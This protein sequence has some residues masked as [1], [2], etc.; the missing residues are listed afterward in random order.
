[1]KLQISKRP[2]AISALM[3]ALIVGAPLL[4]Q[5][6]SAQ[7]YPGPMT[8]QQREELAT[9]IESYDSHYDAAEK[10]MAI[11]KRGGYDY[12]TNLGA[13]KVHPT[14]VSLSYAIALLDSREPAHEAR[15]F[16]ILRRV[17]ELQ[18][19][20]PDSAGYGVWPKYA[21]EALEAAPYIDRNWADF[22]GKDLLY[23][24]LYHEKR[25]PADLQSALKTGILNAA[26]SIRQ[27]NITLAYTNIAV[28]GTYVTLMA[29]EHYG[30]ADLL[31]YARGRLR[32]LSAFTQEFGLIEYNSPNYNLIALEDSQR[33]LRDVRDP[34]DREL[35]SQIHARV[36]RELATHF[37]APTR[38]WIGPYSRVYNLGYDDAHAAWI[39]AHTGP[40]VDWGLVPLGLEEQ[41]A[42]LLCPPELESY[43]APL[44]QARTQ[45]QTFDS[46]ATPPVIG[47]TFLHPQFALGSINQGEMWNQRR[48]LL[49]YWGAPGSVST[50]ALRFLHDG[51]DFQS[52]NI[53]AQQREGRALVALTAMT[54]GGDK[55]PSL[56]RIK[57]ATVKSKDW[58]VRWEFGGAARDVTIVAPDS[59]A[60]NAR[61][62][63]GGLRF[64][65]AAPVAQWG[66]GKGRWE[67]GHDDQTAWLD[68]VLYDGPEKAWKLDEMQRIAVAMALQIS[69]GQAAPMAP[70]KIRNAD[71]Q[72]TL[73][74]NDLA[75]SVSTRPQTAD[76]LRKRLRL[77]S[78]V[79]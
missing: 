66:P 54:D 64:E 33:L 14:R 40:S 68:I 2:R 29:A 7:Y 51:Y 70:V 52:M 77:G 65:I 50:L 71:Q 1:M 20:K 12:T 67:S 27:R 11:T 69:T 21:E 23:V 5:A 44:L 8:P 18:V 38:Q 37:H 19:T 42:E 72:M 76:A 13:E 47:T 53:A 41:N 49:A 43:F 28:M 74:W 55:H 26:T 17:L 63:S 24:A 59:L 35:A 15:A 45:I 48:N 73:S 22:I 78:A 31:D 39:E 62:E 9:Q 30:D 32:R 56:D 10:L 4:A 34:A 75:L 25:L 61:I 36:W 3:L 60:Q 57:N 6:A 16:E 58:R 46:R 79:K